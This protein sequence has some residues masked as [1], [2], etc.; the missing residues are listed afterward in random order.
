MRL[1]YLQ[2]ALCLLWALSLPGLA[3]GQA[4]TQPP[5][6]VY[7]KVA[8]GAS[9]AAHQYTFDGRAKPY[10]DD[11]YG[12]SFYDRS[13]YLYSEGGLADGLTGVVS[14]GYK[15]LVTRDTTFRYEASALGDVD[16]GLRWRPDPI[17]AWIPAGGALAI[18]AKLTLPTGYIRNSI[19]SPGSGQVNGAISVDYGHGW[20]GLYVQGGLGYRLRSGWYGLSR[21]VE[22]QPGRDRGCA[23]DPQQDLGDEV[24]GRFEIGASP[25]K[26][27]LVQGLA[28]AVIS[29]QAPEVGFS[30]D[31]PIPAQQ[32][33]LKLGGGLIGLLG[34]GW[35]LSAQ[36]LYTFW[37]NNTVRSLDIFLGV[38]TEFDVGELFAEVAGP[39]GGAR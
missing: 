1:P 6:H 10:A 32:R 26:W 7:A 31:Q 19:P 5:G 38:H 35:G 36:G 20:S 22:C 29:L 37:G 8:Y 16:L 2:R 34:D 9:T 27:L 25:V 39:R 28:D 18:N 12:P 3:W 24:Y 23:Q 17:M 33:W 13:L 14:L 11:V 30:V 4:W 15:R 21:A